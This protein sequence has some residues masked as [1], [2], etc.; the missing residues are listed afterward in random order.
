[1]NATGAILENKLEMTE[2]HV[3]QFFKGSMT[4]MLV[5]LQTLSNKQPSSLRH[6]LRHTY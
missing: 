6:V 5:D 4:E 3:D 2:F 1:M